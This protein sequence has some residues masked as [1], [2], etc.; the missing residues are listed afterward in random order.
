MRKRYN[1]YELNLMTVIVSF[2][3]FQLENGW[4]TITCG[5][6]D[7]RSMNLPFLLGYGLTIV[8]F[9][10]FVGTPN[11]IRVGEKNHR[12]LTRSQSYILYFLIAMVIVSL[13][14]ILLGTIVED[15]FGFR[16]WD[17]TRIPLHITKYTSIPT[18]MMFAAVITIFMGY[19]YEPLMESIHHMPK[20]AVKV[21]GILM[22]ILL[23]T[24]FLYCFEFMYIHQ[25][26]YEKWIRLI[27]TASL[28]R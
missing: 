16:Y 28:L 15:K 13:G 26:P 20:R 5:Y 23:V 7:N 19:C 9:Y 22:M 11:N 27:G 18:S 25:G 4:L 3:G 10:I 12:H 24:D 1:F 14:E 17:Y 8:G 6:M 2:M 21:I